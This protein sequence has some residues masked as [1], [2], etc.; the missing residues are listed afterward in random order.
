MTATCRSR[1]KAYS[2]RYDKLRRLGYHM[3]IDGTVTRRK[4]RALQ[5]I[6]Y[7][8]TEMGRRI[9]RHQQSLSDTLHGDA[10]VHRTTARLID[11]LYTELHM[12]PAVGPVAE[13]TRKMAARLG[14]APPL[15]WDDIDNDELPADMKRCKRGLHALVGENLNS[16]GEC[17]PCKNAYQRE[18]WAAKKKVAA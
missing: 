8:L 16:R 17:K 3:H 2:R 18:H 5:A 11:E 14:Y 9:G 10:P 13:R 7:T 12:T 1:T 4:M 6:G 15:A